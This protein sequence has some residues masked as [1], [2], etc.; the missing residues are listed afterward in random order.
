MNWRTGPRASRHWLRVT[1]QL[2]SLVLLGLLLWL[3]GMDVWQNILSGDP[4]DILMAFALLGAASMLAAT[5]LQ[6]I[7]RAITGKDSASWRRFYHLSMTTRAA[8]LVVP[9]SLS[10]FAGKPVGLRGMGLSIKRAVWTVIVDNVLDLLVVGTW[11]IPSLFILQHGISVHAVTALTAVSTLLLVA[12]LWWATGAERFSPLVR[13][14]KRVP[15]LN[16]RV[17]AYRSGL[18][19]LVLARVPAL[20]ALGLSV[21]INGL[22]AA[23]SGCIGRAIGLSHPWL[24]FLAGFPITQLSLVLAVTPGGIG[25]LDASWYGVLI[26]GGMSHQEAITFVIA[27]RAYVSVFVLVWA[28]ISVFLSLTERRRRE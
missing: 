12:G 18:D 15:W 19:E 17:P 6:L 2:L 8:G 22:L 5:R 23:R 24:I 3:G 21:L 10:T 26:L 27:Q 25:T 14:L 1:L 9:R 28:A 11:L 20:Q 13:L 4:K 7:S 16:A